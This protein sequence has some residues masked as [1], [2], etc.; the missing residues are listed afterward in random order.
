[1]SHGLT[2]TARIGFAVVLLALPVFAFQQ[3]KPFIPGAFF[4]VP[5]CLCG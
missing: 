2:R 3:A 5:L 4:S 1:M